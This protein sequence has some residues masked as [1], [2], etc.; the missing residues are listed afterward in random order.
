[1]AAPLPIVRPGASWRV[2]DARTGATRQV[3]GG[4]EKV[5]VQIPEPDRSERETDAIRA[6]GGTGAVCYPTNWGRVPPPAGMGATL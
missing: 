1:M 6:H 2:R 5:P 4:R 3:Q